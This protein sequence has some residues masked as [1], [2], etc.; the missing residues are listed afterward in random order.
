MGLD[1]IIWVV[2]FSVVVLVYIAIDTKSTRTLIYSLRSDIYDQKTEIQK[3]QTEIT[4]LK[5]EIRILRIEN[6][7][8]LRKL[9]DIKIKE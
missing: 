9:A 2:L 3:L 8:L 7:G 6:L 1:W 5:E 4:A